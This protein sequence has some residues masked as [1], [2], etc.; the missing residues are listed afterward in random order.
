MEQRE[1]VIKQYIAAYNSFDV[2]GMLKD[3][4]ENIN[5]E[6]ISGGE[7][8]LSITGISAFREQAEKAKA[9]FVSRKQT[10]T[11]FRHDANQT[12]ID[13]DYHAVLAI[14]FSDTLKKGDTLNMKGKSV[15]NFLHSKITSITDVS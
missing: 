15:F 8:N 9:F 3:L 1:Q 5:F 10:I 4:D 7:V 12:E 13:I 6:N 14:D 11:A 2:E